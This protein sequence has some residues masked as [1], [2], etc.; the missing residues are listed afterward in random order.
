MPSP[1]INSADLPIL[2]F[3]GRVTQY[4]PQALPMGASPFNQD[5]IFSG[6]TPD[7]VGMVG[8][9]ASRPGMQ[10][11]YAAR[12]NGNPSVN[13]LKTFVDSQDII[14]L[15]SLDSL[16]NMR[17]ES[18]CPTVPNVPTIIGTVVAASLAQSD[19][20]INR[21]W[22]ATSSVATGFGI[23]IPRQWDGTYFDRVSQVG[24]GAAPSAADANAS[25]Q[26][27][28]ASPNGLVNLKLTGVPLTENAGILSIQL[29][30]TGI[31]SNAPEWSVPLFNVGDSLT[32]SA[33][34][35]S[36]YD[37]SYGIL[38]VDAVAQIITV[39]APAAVTGAAQCTVSTS[40]VLVSTTD[41]VEGFPQIG[42]SVT[43]A[44]ATDS[45]YDLTYTIRQSPNSS[46]PSDATY[47]PTYV[48]VLGDSQMWLGGTLVGEAAS[49]GG[50][51]TVVG[52]ITAGLRQVAVCFL[53][54]ENYI[55]KP[56]PPTSWVAAGGLQVSVTDIPI[57]PPNVI[58]R[59]VIFTPT[60]T[61][62]A[63]TG[64]FY[65]FDGAVP[66]PNGLSFPTMVIPDNVTT[67]ATFDFIDSVLEE[68]EPA[69]SLYNLLELG[70]CSCSCA[71]SDRMFWAGERNKVSNFLNLTFDGGFASDTPLG[72]T[73]EAGGGTPSPAPYWGGAYRITGQGLATVGTIQQTCYQDYLG[74]P[75][76]AATQGPGYMVRVR[77]Q[78]GGG[79]NAGSATIAIYSPSEGTL[80][81]F[82]VPYNQIPVGSYAEFIG[83]LL[84]ANVNIPSD[85]VLTV[86][87]TGT[88]NNGGFVDFDC[89]EVYP[90]N[91]PYNTTVV[92]GSYASDPESFDG[93]TGYLVVGQENG[94]AVKAM[95]QLLDNKLYIVKERSLYSTQDDY[96]NEPSSWNINTVSATVGT[97]SA[98]GVGVGE[99][100]AIIAAHDGAY[101]FWGGEPVKISQEIQP[102]WDQINWAYASTIYVVVD[103]ANKRIHIGAP[104]N[105]STVPNVEFVCDYAQLANSE[106]QTAAQD[107]AAHPQAYY[108]VYNPTRIVAPG[109]ARKW[110]I[111]NIS[112]NCGALTVRSDGSYHLLRGN[113]TGTGKIYDQVVTQLSDDGVAINSQYQT[114]FFP[115]VEDEQALQLGSHRKLLKYLTGYCSG[116]GSLV[117]VAYAAQNQRAVYLSPLPLQDPS[118]EDFEKNC[119]FISERISLLCQIDAVGSWFKMSKLIP[120]I[121]REIVTPV[122][123]SV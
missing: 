65:Y 42:A 104:I 118:Y 111:W 69:T 10:N 97:E 93:T 61:P 13:Y 56:S 87:L 98:R 51:I 83:E 43:I 99:S 55:T 54:R 63:T 53:T 49:G 16:G 11:F 88:A 103:T 77:L 64:S 109:K 25:T 114:A 62:P 108:S 31:G 78:A 82:S 84:A 46:L 119:N 115:Q 32:I 39:T 70:E 1:S 50:T 40:L 59:I 81:S 2:T 100:W 23:D 58:G 52:G 72:W 7:G 112:M 116:V 68:G 75:I 9:V 79:L 113:A 95:F 66:I 17:D 3:G 8:G 33:S 37:G 57:G 60:I 122:R 71:Y 91:L 45:N 123:G 107:I 21:E 14:H 102:D 117:W 110:T 41:P 18:P 105:G 121:Q 24:P 101:I 29:G 5:V 120:N 90:T 47:V 73:T 26:A 92:R 67:S 30:V 96:S 85:A 34:T 44:G 89:I 20:L 35:V 48:S 80:G 19:S 6:I 12:F 76:L 4:D 106:G 94:Q 36:G 74:V 86:S 15:L 38:S 28:E 22:I 27:I